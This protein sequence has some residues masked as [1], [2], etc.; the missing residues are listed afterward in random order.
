MNADAF[1]PDEATIRQLHDAYLGGHYSCER[2]VEHYLDRIHA[3][4]Q[5]GPRLRA[6]IHLNP[7]ILHEARELDRRRLASPGGLGALHGVPV[8]IKDNIDVAGLPTSGGLAAFARATPAR[9]AFIVRQLRRAGALFIGKCNLHELALGGTTVSTLGGQTL[10]PYA[11][12]RTPGGSSGGTG[13]AVAAGMAMAGIGTDTGQ[14][15]RSPASALALVGI[16]PTYG[17]V[18]RSGVM[19]T[20]ITQDTVGPLARTV[21]DAARV[22]AA[23]AGFDAGDPATA[24]CFPA[25]A[26]FRAPPEGRKLAE[27][28][29]GIVEQFFGG[30]A[31]HTAVNRVIHA[32]AKQMEALGA[33]LVPVVIPGLEALMED[34][35]TAAYEMQAAF[36]QYVQASLGLGAD[37][38]LSALLASG[39]LHPSIHAS[40]QAALAS[41]GHDDPRYGRIFLKRARLR[42]AVLLAMATASL[43][44]LLYPHQSILVAPLGSHRQA[45]RNGVLSNATGMPAICFPAGFS[46]AGP[47]GA[48][49][50]IGAELLGRDG[51]EA[52]LIAYA[53]AY[54]CAT[55]HRRPT[56]FP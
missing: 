21:E 31:R 46:E 45:E 12:D 48:A 22:L 9:D 43:D 35:A 23:I 55:R 17:L 29:I 44:A 8:A 26:E 38:S 24:A 32:A 25:R 34:Q 6:F 42:N 20:S 16:R 27:A 28:R 50:P 56:D 18:S 5:A 39:G 13:V 10:N 52:G 11:L 33:T 19:P 51:S 40:V 30:E 53:H 41:Q 15:I 7:R 2:L 49:I 47:D 3:L 54:E 37:H 36:D 14:S 1:V 4:D